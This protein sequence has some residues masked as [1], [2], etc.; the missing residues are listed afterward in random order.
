[1]EEINDDLI[2]LINEFNKKYSRLKQ[3]LPYHLNVIDELHVNENA[4]SRILAS[5]LLYKTNGDYPLLKSF[6]E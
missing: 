3:G 2:K 6:I 4:N 1:M 5:L